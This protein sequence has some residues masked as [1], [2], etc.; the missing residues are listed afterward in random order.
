[1]RRSSPRAPRCPRRRPTSR[2]RWCCRIAWSCC[3]GDGAAGEVVDDDRT[4]EPGDPGLGAV[5]LFHPRAPFAVVD[6]LGR[7]PRLPEI[8]AAG[9]AAVLGT[10]VVFADQPRKVLVLRRARFEAPCGLG[11]R[12]RRG[13]PELHDGGDHDRVSSPNSGLPEFGTLDWSKSETSDFDGGYR[14]A[15]GSAQAE[16]RRVVRSK[17]STRLAKLTLVVLVTAAVGLSLMLAGIFIG[18]RVHTGL[19]ELA[20]RR[21]VSSAL[22]ASG[23][24]LLLKSG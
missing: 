2:V 23:L 5:E 8:D 11:E 16:L 1:M 10:D 14:A 9:D 21:T 3:L 18:N 22:I 17:A 24:A 7:R 12:D 13:Q 15:A 20:F 4:V 6:P 19:S